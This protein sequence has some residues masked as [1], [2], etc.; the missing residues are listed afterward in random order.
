MSGEKTKDEPKAEKSFYVLKDGVSDKTRAKLDVTFGV[1]T[2]TFMNT[3]Q[4][5]AK[6]NGSIKNSSS[7][8]VSS[9]IQ[10]VDLKEI[11][12][13][14]PMF[15]MIPGKTIDEHHA[16]AKKLDESLQKQTGMVFSKAVYTELGTDLGQ[17][18]TNYIGSEFRTG[19]GG[20]RCFGIRFGL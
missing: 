19:N 12:K 20:S 11:Y 10:D 3:M 6:E 5:I 14:L 16:D 1:S 9:D 15:K 17:L 2:W 8:E 4:D 7:T 18:Q 13:A